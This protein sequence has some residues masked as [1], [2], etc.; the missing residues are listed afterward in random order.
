MD[1]TFYDFKKNIINLQ[2]KTTALKGTV[3]KYWFENKNIQ[4]KKTLFHNIN[5][6][7]KPFDSGID[8]ESQPIET[9]LV[10]E[11]LN[12]GITNPYELN[13]IEISS[14]KYSDLEASIYLGNV[15]NKIEVE[16]LFFEK[17]DEIE[18]IDS[19]DDYL[20]KD[21]RVSKE[22]YTAATHDD[23]ELSRVEDKIHAALT[24]LSQSS[25]PQTGWSINLFTWFM[26]MLD[27]N[28]ITIQEHHIDMKDSLNPWNKKTKNLWQTIKDWFT[29]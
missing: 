10:F 20:P 19:I 7:L 12:L 16:S 14:N 17:I 29:K 3:E 23:T 5:I 27:K 22:E 18:A 4:L 11:W 6:P 15:H 28:L 8:Y 2:D 9:S 26:T 13:K 25:A 1:E 24:H 21:M